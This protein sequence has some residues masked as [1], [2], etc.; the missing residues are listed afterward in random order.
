VLLDRGSALTVASD[1]VLLVC[2]C[3]SRQP[4]PGLARVLAREWPHVRPYD[5]PGTRNLTDVAARP[6]PGTCSFLVDPDG[7]RPTVACLFAQYLPNKGSR[8]SAV[9]AEQKIVD[10]RETRE[11]WRQ[12]CLRAVAAYVDKHPAIRRVV[13]P[14]ALVRARPELIELTHADVRELA[15][16]LSADVTVLRPSCGP[17]AMRDVQKH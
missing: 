16:A 1:L 15:T 14:R 9:A 2:D 5:R 12:S 7:K 4:P 8:R 17:E 13:V 10:T 11:V 6:A 3:V